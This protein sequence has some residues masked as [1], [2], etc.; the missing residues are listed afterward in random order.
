MERIY[1]S[2]IEKNS[3]I[4]TVLDALGAKYFAPITVNQ[5][6][7]SCP[8]GESFLAKLRKYEGQKLYVCDGQHKSIQRLFREDPHVGLKIK[9]DSPNLQTINGV[10]DQKCRDYSQRFESHKDWNRKL[11]T[12]E[13]NP[14]YGK[15]YWILASQNSI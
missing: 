4:Q 14:Y 11:P 13:P 8:A 1:Y 7:K 10:M 6:E 12:G 3:F 9:G 15:K 5:S 2:R